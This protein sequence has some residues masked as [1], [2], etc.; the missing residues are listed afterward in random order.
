MKKLLMTAA[1]AAVALGLGA[2]AS[3]AEKYK[4]CWVYV[5]PVGDGGY[6]FQHD[7]GRKMVDKELGDKVET[8]FVENVAEADADRAIERL[9]RDG[10]KMIFT[11]SFGFMEPTLKVAAKFPGCEV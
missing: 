10:C 2:T 9:A 6:T 5:G 3:L 1:V 4:A 7:V 8:V 11:T